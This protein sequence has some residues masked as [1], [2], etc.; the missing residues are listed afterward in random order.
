M[1]YLKAMITTKTYTNTT[2]KTI[3]GLIVFLLFSTSNIKAQSLNDYKLNGKVK[4][5]YKKTYENS[6]DG[7]LDTITPSEYVFVDFQNRK[8]TEIHKKNERANIS[9][10]YYDENR[11]CILD[12]VYTKRDYVEI[13]KFYYD[14][15]GNRIKKERYHND[16]LQSTTSYVYNR[17]DN[18][19][20]EFSV[21]NGD[22]SLIELYIYDSNMYEKSHINNE[23]Y[24]KPYTYVKEYNKKGQLIKSYNLKTKN[25]YTL[26]KYDRKGNLIKE[27]EYD[28]N[29]CTR[30]II[31]IYNSHNKLIKEKSYYGNELSSTE[32]YIYDSLNRKAQTIFWEKGE[33]LIPK[34]EIVRFDKK[35]R[36][37]ERKTYW[38]DAPP[39][40][41]RL[42]YKDDN[43][44]QE[45]YDDPSDP[46]EQTYKIEYTYNTDNTLSRKV[47]YSYNDGEREKI[48]WKEREIE[49]YSYNSE[50]QN[51]FITTIKVSPNY[52]GDDSL[53]YKIRNDSL[54]YKNGLLIKRYNCE[55]NDNQNTYKYDEKG[56][57][58]EEDINENNRTLITYKYENNVLTYKCEQIGTI[59]NE[60]KYDSNKRLIEH[61]YNNQYTYPYT[62]SK[63]NYFYN[64]KGKLKKEIYKSNERYN[65]IFKYKYKLFS[66]DYKII[67]NVTS[68]I[69]NV[70]YKYDDKG[71]LIEERYPSYLVR[72]E[73]EYYQ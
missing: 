22:S 23:T 38:N 53:I 33:Y 60:W 63:T 64:S 6:K 51:N 52:L 44:V 9:V 71:N 45:I 13:T 43:L 24:H 5:F 47:R 56:R 35:G 59:T 29:K 66:K 20:K 67:N 12:S 40:I 4:S 21:Q 2:N 16:I 17:I 49:E 8:E 18:L 32:T 11:N 50:K 19:I 48:K 27:I 41:H 46:Y 26:F 34:K 15:K 37:I 65:V 28:N 58:I 42:K 73:Y 7:Y 70:Y 61:V 3:I 36:L 30:K 55:N 31:Y 57:L 1:L 39:I 25:S 69:E 72:F 14:I 54:I 62:S 68:N 10:K